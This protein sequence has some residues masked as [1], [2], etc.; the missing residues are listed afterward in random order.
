MNPISSNPPHTV[1]RSPLTSFEAAHAGAAQHWLNG[2]RLRTYSLVALTCYAVFLHSSTCTGPSG[3]TGPTSARWRLD[4]LPF[5]SASFLA[6][7]RHAIDAYNVVALTA[8]ET[9]AISRDPGIL[10]WLYPP[11]LPAGGVSAGAAAV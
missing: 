9:D 3:S 8:V 6:L 5:W 7:H 1:R 10:P 4:F 2:E 11:T